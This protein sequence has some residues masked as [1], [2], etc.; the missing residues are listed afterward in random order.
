MRRE[1]WVRLDNASNIFLAAMNNRDTKVFR[2]TAEMSELVDPDI[3]QQALEKTYE[4][5]LLYH[6]VLRRGFFWYYLA[7][8]ELKP[9]VAVEG[10]SPCA[11]IYHFDQKELL[12]RVVY[13]QKRIHLEVFHVLSD[14]T[15]AMWFFEDLI[16][17]YIFIRYNE[18][19]ENEHK[20][21]SIQW[22]KQ[23]EDSFNQHF[24]QQRQEPFAEAARSAFFSV[25][26]TSKRAG[27]VAVQ[28]GKKTSSWF[29]SSLE[30][31]SSK[32]RVYQ[33]KG[34]KTPDNRPRIVELNLPLGAVL[35]LAKKQQVSLT[36]Y[37]IALFFESIR[38]AE[39]QF[40]LT[41]T[42]AV[43]V[44]VNLR[45]F[46]QS[47]SARNFFS[48]V[49]LEYT[50]GEDGNF[51]D[52]CRSLNEQLQE[53]LKQ[54][55][56]KERLSKLIKAEYHPIGRVVP[57]PLK[58]LILKGINRQNNRKLTVAMSNLGSVAFSQPVNQHIQHFFFQTSAVRP[59]FCMISFK[60]TL[61]ISFTSPFVE[62]AIQKEFVRLLTA[63]SVPVVVG[64]NQVTNAELKG[65]TA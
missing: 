7:M 1:T 62:T 16:K 2:L 4:Q 27:K 54:E 3:L 40:Q 23:L 55:K 6:S 61:T 10:L 65:E 47:Y 15:G 26:E 60:D 19:T 17:E 42:L 51:D 45:Q 57:R 44:P 50:Y 39:P 63:E 41:D 12:F 14:G 33:I 8:S 49:R 52:L 58:D 48:T 43:S 38:K 5:S 64:V 24:R 28:Y 59:Q 35:S 13:W 46:F 36:V 11:P 31:D 20:K 37:L 30:M 56:L 25:V 21:T 32:K 18:R 9:K 22:E 29:T 53:H 34:K